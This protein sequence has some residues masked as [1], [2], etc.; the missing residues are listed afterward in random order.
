[1]TSSAERLRLELET[2]GDVDL[3]ALSEPITAGAFVELEEEIDDAAASLATFE[4]QLVAMAEATGDLAAERMEAFKAGISGSIV[5]QANIEALA[6]EL[7]DE[8][9]GMAYQL[10]EDDDTA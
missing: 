9:E 8:D 2:L 1:M 6:L 3:T 5:K 4:E 7:Q 10:M